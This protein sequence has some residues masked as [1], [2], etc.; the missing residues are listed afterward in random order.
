MTNLKTHNSVH[1]LL[2]NVDPKKNVTSKKAQP[3]VKKR[4]TTLSKNS[5]EQHS[6]VSLRF[7]LFIHQV[8]IYTIFGSCAL[9]KVEQKHC[10]LQVNIQLI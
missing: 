1:F 7:S 2:T 3:V 10:S 8:S 9:V 4:T 6:S 5:S